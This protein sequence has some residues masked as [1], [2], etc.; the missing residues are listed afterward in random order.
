[1]YFLMIRPQQARRRQFMELMRTL[2]VGDEV[3]TV[4]G[5]FGAIRRLD[6]DTIWL[7]VAPGTTLR[8]SRGAVRRKVIQEEESDDRTP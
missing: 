8:F 1:M 5:I 6:E 7:E 3:E 2:E 4:A